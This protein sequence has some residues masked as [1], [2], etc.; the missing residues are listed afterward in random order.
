MVVKVLVSDFDKTLFTDNYKENVRL[1]NEFV[2]K[3]NMFIIATGRNL[4][5]LLSE[6]DDDLRFS[7]LVCNNGGIIFDTNLKVV[8]KKDIEI[9]LAR[10]V[11]DLL[12]KNVCVG[13]PLTCELG[14]YNDLFGNSC[15]SIVA[16][17]VNR[18]K[19]YNLLNQILNS[20]FAVNGYLSDRWIN[21]IAE[22][23]SKGNALMHI[24]DLIGYD[25][26]EAFA[27]GDSWNDISMCEICNGYAIGSGCLELERV[28]VKTIDNIGVLL[29][30]LK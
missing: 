15:N 27:V 19:S 2:S 25:Y 23:V 8:Y 17:I 28:C 21:I 3:G 1:V 20:S 11:F 18:D 30:L 24:C 14:D 29:E 26:K 4:A 9:N 12:Q 5:S 13:N 22:G 10:N 7:Y 6:L 16:R